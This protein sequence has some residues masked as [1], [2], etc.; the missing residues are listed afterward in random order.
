M[1]SIA[2]LAHF[3]EGI[4]RDSSSFYTIPQS[5]TFASS[6]WTLNLPSS[7]PLNKGKQFATVDS[8]TY[9]SASSLDFSYRTAKTNESSINHYVFY[10]PDA[11][12]QRPNEAV[13][14]KNVMFNQS[15]V[16]TILFLKIL[17]YL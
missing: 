2:N 6:N 5:S 15:K 16:C 14:E 8:T 17:F 12:I 4:Q 1:S 11:K 9:A 7:I 3:E 13:M 10:N